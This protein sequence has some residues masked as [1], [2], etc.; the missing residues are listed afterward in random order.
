MKVVTMLSSALTF[1]LLLSAMA[2]GLW[3]KSGGAGSI[4]FHMTCGILAII[5]SLV[6]LILIGVNWPRKEEGRAKR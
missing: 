3:L 4:K 5:F 2:C 6:T 1:L